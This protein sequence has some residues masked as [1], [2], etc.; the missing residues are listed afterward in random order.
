[1]SYTK[2]G[3]FLRIQRIKHHE[4]MGDVAQLLGVS[5]PFL[6]AVEN[7]KKNIPSEWLDILSKHYHL[8][9]LENIE[10]RQAAEHSKNYV[11]ITLSGAKPFQREAALQFARSFDEMDD[12]TA[13]KITELLKSNEA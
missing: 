6:S 4:V 9:E 3:E 8:D 2:F 7:G 1:M 5:V 13:K 10:M 12:N 11:K